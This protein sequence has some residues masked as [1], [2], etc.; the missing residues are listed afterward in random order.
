MKVFRRGSLLTD[1]SLT[2][3]TQIF[4]TIVGITLL[5]MLALYLPEEGLGIYLVFRRVGGMG[6]SL[7]T[8]NLG[9]SLARYIS[10][11]KQKSED[12][13]FFSLI[14][15]TLIG[16]SLSLIFL[17]LPNEFAKLLFGDEKFGT[18]L[19]P[20]ILFLLANSYIVLCQNYFRGKQ[21]FI[22]MNVVNILFWV[23]ALVIVFI[24]FLRTTT[25]QFLVRYFWVH[26]VISIF[27]VFLFI[28]LPKKPSGMKLE[29]LRHGMSFK[30]YMYSKDFFKYGISR[31]P[32]SL[33]LAGIFTLPILIASSS[34]SLT[35]TA[36]IGIIV[37]IIR[38][39]Q[40]FMQPFNLI[41]LPKFAEYQAFGNRDLIRKNSQSVL[42][43]T[44]SVPFI[45]GLLVAFFS[46]EIILLWFGEKYSIVI[47]YLTYL[48]PTI[49]LLFSFILLHGILDGLFEKPYANI[50]T[51]VAFLIEL[52]L[53]VAALIFKWNL[54]GL[55]IGIGAGISVLGLMTIL[56]LVRK[57]ELDFFQPRIIS[58][59][60]WFGFIWA[61]TS[62]LNRF[63]S[64]DYI[65]RAIVLKILIALGLSLFSFGFYYK[66]R[67]AW[68]DYLFKKQ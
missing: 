55:T 44:F 23:F 17:L 61:A 29:G 31:L 26:S 30:Y 51:V 8:L 7:L 35:V 63:L 4:I 10:I 33:L 57:T 18:L 56:I 45:F 48:S 62:F 54:L 50:I 27:I 43:Y 22:F 14:L 34:I 24:P 9:M 19:P 39:A 66:L 68:I 60:V 52:A 67:F 16:G 25:I 5:K 32:S 40:I 47:P 28:V 13:L 53:L 41:F 42:E 21:Q 38:M 2:F 1:V 36:Y 15:T 12:F 3:F 64:L 49:G 20:M 59:I 58:S 6:Y 46:R 37:S 11:D 65:L